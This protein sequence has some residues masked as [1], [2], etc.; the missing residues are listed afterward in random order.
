M[1]YF[2]SFYL[3]KEKDIIVDLFREEE[4][5]YYVLKTPNHT[6]GNL[7]TNL[8]RLCDLP[9]SRDEQGLLVIRGT[10][11][12]YI[13]GYNRTLYIFRLGNTKVANIYPDGLVE[14]KAYIPA[15]SKTLMSQTKDYRLDEQRTIVKTYIR[16]ECKF[17]SDLHT[18]MNANL[19]PD[20]LIALGI[21]H[22]IRYPLYYI[23]KLNL[24]LTESQRKALEIQRE[25]VAED[26]ADCGLT[27]K[28]LT[29]RIDDNTFI[30]FADLIL[31]CPE[32]ASSNIAKVRR[33][34]AVLKD[35]QAV[36]TNLEKVYLYRYVFT[37]GV[38]MRDVYPLDSYENIPDPDI[39]WYIA[40][41]LK[42]REHPVFMDNTLFEDKLLWIAR[43]YKAQ[44][45]CYAEIS[46]TTLVK[47]ESAGK[48]LAQVHRIMPAVTDETGVL[49]RFLAAIRRIPL[50][51][52]K[53]KVTPGDYFTENLSVLEAVA[54]DPY[55]AGSDILGEEINDIRD[56]HPV[57]QK[58]TQIAADVP[59]FVM[60]IHAGENDSLR[61]NV[62]NSI[63]CVKDSL[64]E[65]QKM[66]NLRIGHGLY[67][68]N[69]S[70]AKGK[71]LIREL[72]DT[73]TVLEFQIS[74]NVRLNNLS[75]M[76]R[77]PLRQYLS[78]DLDCVQGT[79]GGALYGTD[80][81]DEQLSLEKLLGLSYDELLRMK[82]SEGEILE[83][84][85]KAF[86]EKQA[87]WKE[88]LDVETYYKEQIVKHSKASGIQLLGE[89]GLIAKEALADRI[90]ELPEEGLPIVLVGG[91][92]NNDRH[93]TKVR[94]DGRRIIDKLLR[95]GD[96]EK[97]FFVVG[98]RIS[99]YEKYLIDHNM[100]RFRIYAFVPSMITEREKQKLI[101]SGVKIRI[102]IES[103]PMGLYKS[104]AY[105][106]FKRRGCVLLAL[107]GNSSGANMIQE[108]KNAKYKSSIYVSSHS[109]TLRSKADSLEGYVTIFD[110]KTA[111]EVAGKIL[112]TI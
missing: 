8:A 88:L 78:Y 14:M 53:D 99:G 27:G 1:D 85:L 48:M 101:A 17:R 60:R 102:S 76:G 105:E 81:I 90:E 98:H 95:Q 97:I 41:I 73:G 107:D 96:P 46:D 68:A 87:A 11:P 71:A 94:E 5:L 65:G 37:K 13:D 111:A 79:D 44:G 28:Y 36:F 91:S 64:A 24:Q 70:S 10:V 26:H 52:I 16:R 50:T 45:I 93:T 23:K 74:S 31:G 106:V 56:I 62:A 84:S 20:I 89:R 6:T 109:R 39:V 66:P 18:H 77:H 54:H 21:C 72:K 75:T 58:I 15:V 3:D 43:S 49:L 112:S 47:A 2:K 12:C 19:P 25:Q 80:P 38:P 61:D 108:A 29:R 9:L 57:I 51:I 22:Q 4:A 42:D 55:V 40:R 30:N 86:E 69:L 63:L 67:T 110:E 92:F 33:S 32:H 34:L 83:K 59:G 103:S 100:D 35:G 82:E 7:I 104:I